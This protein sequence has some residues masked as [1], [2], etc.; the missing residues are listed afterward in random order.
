[1]KTNN[2]AGFTLIELMTVIAI[3][4][5]LSAMAYASYSSAMTK[6][7]RSEGKSAL[8]K[9]MQQEERFY[10]QNNSYI[11]FSQASSDAN[12]KKFNWFSGDSAR[13]SA[14]EIRAT[15]CNG[16][17]IQNCVLLTATPGT[18]SVDGNFKDKVCGNLTITSTGIKGFT[19]TNGTKEECW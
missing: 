11:V 8:M 19:G 9:L 10:T 3:M 13:K 7:K 4:G 17:T 5:I 12:E 16:D 1:M 2:K 15:A 18:T 6:A 14:Y